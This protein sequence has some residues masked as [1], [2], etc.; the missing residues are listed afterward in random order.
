M[1][2][3]KEYQQIVEEKRGKPLKDIMYELCI[4][5]NVI[6]IQGANI[7]KVPKDVFL[8]WRNQFR[9]G[10]MQFAYD[11]SERMNAKRNGLYTK[12]LEESDLTRPLKL[13]DEQ[14][15]SGFKEVIQRYLEITKAKLLIHEL[16]DLE[17]LNL[18]MRI[19]SIEC[20]LDLLDSYCD[21]DFSYKYLKDMSE[22]KKN[23]E[24]KYKR[25]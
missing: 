14:S 22:V 25:N 16:D 13:A 5:K 7:L 8:Y 21:G 19:A 10:P 24:E 12:E 11:R 15:L 2:K 18:Q 6:P 20:T 17:H 1:L 4:E 3:K 9:F 23:L